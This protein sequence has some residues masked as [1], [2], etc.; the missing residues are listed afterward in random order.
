MY[1]KV[2]I[3]LDGSKLAEVALPY[4]EELAGKMSSEIILLTVLQSEEAHEY[5]NHHSYTSKIVDVTKRHVEKYIDISKRKA[6]RVGTATRT[7]NPAE[8][9][10]DYV[11]KGNHNIIV[12]ATH[13]RSG[14]SRWAVGS[15]ADKVVRA[16]T[17]LPLMLIRAKGAHPDIRAKRVLK[18]A[19]VPLDGSTGSEAVIP[20]IMEIAPSLKMEL[21][22]LRVIPKTNHT[23]DDAE[24][25]LQSWCG[26]LEDQGITT[27]YELRVGAAADQIIDLA[28]ELAID[29]VAMSTHGQNAINLWPL[30]SVAQKVLLAGNTALLLIRA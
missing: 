13:G 24:D 6:I 23:Y 7:G 26:W 8:G 14:I 10:L 27:R 18:K 1:K 29:V 28:D 30:G 4:A 9:I 25:Y 19:L 21:T 15:V 5:Q 17:R 16:T 22:F 3:P 20:Y 11:S 2:V 12:M